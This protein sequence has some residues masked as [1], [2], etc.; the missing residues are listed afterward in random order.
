MLRQAQHDSQLYFNLPKLC[1]TTG[2][3]AL[4]TQKLNQS[5]G[6]LP[7]NFLLR[8]YFRRQEK[9]KNRAAGQ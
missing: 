5:M 7:H 6:A 4:S 9:K 1:P 2:N 3:A 8:G